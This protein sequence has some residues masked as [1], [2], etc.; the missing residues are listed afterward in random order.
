MESLVFMASLAA[1]VIVAG[2]IIRFGGA[3]ISSED[4]ERIREHPFFHAL[5]FLVAAWIVA[6]LFPAISGSPPES[7]R[8]AKAQVVVVGLTTAMKAFYAEYGHWP[9]QSSKN[10]D[11]EYRPDYKQ[12][13]AAVGGQN[14]REI[15]FYEYPQHDFDKQGRYLDSWKHPFNVLADWNGDG[16]ITVG[17]NRVQAGVVVWSNGPNGINE[18]GEGDDIVSWN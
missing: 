17:T 10:E 9:L 13:L 16:D 12:C 6:S 1:L 5:W 15:V 3:I 11:K 14:P 8:R 4:R 2:A 18:F 7:A